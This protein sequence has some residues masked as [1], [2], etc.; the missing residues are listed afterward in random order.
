MLRGRICVY[1]VSFNGIVSVIIIVFRDFV[2]IE[3]SVFGLAL[4]RYDT[5]RQRKEYHA[6]QTQ[7]IAFSTQNKNQGKR[8]ANLGFSIFIEAQLSFLCR[9]KPRPLGNVNHRKAKPISLCQCYLQR[10]PSRIR[11]VW[12]ISLGITTRPRSSIL[13]TIPVAFIYIKSPCFSD[14]CC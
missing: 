13:L 1:K 3:A 5:R 11:M 10:S 2:T 7:V 4:G 6:L 12:R 9:I 8:N 14:L